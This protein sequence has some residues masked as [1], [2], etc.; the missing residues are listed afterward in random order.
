M[1]DPNLPVDPNQSSGTSGVDEGNPT[2]QPQGAQADP[3]QLPSNPIPPVPPQQE[4]SEED[5]QSVTT[6][7]VGVHTV[8]S[9]SDMAKPVSPPPAEPGTDKNLLSPSAPTSAGTLPA[10]QTSS[11]GIQSQG[12]GVLQ[13]DGGEG[14]VVPGNPQQAGGEGGDSPGTSPN[15]AATVKQPPSMP[16]NVGGSMP[17]G[18]AL[19]ETQVPPVPQQQPPVPLTATSAQAG[20]PASDPQQSTDNSPSTGAAEELKKTHEPVIILP[21]RL[22]MGQMV[23]VKVKVG[24]IGHVMEEAHHIESI[25]LFSNDQSIGKTDLKPGENI[26]AEV[27][28]QVPLTAGAQ[29]KA[30]ALCNVHGKWESVRSI[31]EFTS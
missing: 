31:P 23:N 30:V 9:I 26:S 4:P 2:V 1:Q 7:G 22:E 25:E 16:A 10:V 3:N 11:P 13:P 18:G 24:M 6:S 19:H 20:Q 5:T 29:L 28:F 15:P 17:P 8:P 21:D 14:T 27:D 12:E